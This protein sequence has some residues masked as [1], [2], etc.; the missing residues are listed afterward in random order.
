MKYS[1]ADMSTMENFKIEVE[2]VDKG[3]VEEN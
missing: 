1:E 2:T 3:Y